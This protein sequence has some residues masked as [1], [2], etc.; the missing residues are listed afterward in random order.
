MYL[1]QNCSLI[2]EG[3]I[4]ESVLKLLIDLTFESTIKHIF[5]CII[6]SE[7]FKEI[8]RDVSVQLSSRDLLDS[9]M[10]DLKS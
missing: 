3:Q 5:K 2:P 8:Y 10:K 4:S 1:T 7:A 9:I 6:L